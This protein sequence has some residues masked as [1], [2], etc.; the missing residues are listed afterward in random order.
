MKLRS[1]NESHTREELEKSLREISFASVLY[2]HTVL[3]SRLSVLYYRYTQR[4]RQNAHIRTI[5]S[6]LWRFL[7]SFSFFSFF[8]LLCFFSFLCLFCA[9]S[10]L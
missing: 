8:C 9:L 6:F 5:Y 3:R 2:F 1:R 4:R 7:F 10:D